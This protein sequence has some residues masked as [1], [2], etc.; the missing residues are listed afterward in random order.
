MTAYDYS[1]AQLVEEAG[2]DVILVGDSV[3]TTAMG[4]DSTLPV[5]LD[6]MIYH[7]TLVRRGAPHTMMVVDLPF[8]T[9]TDRDTALKSAGRIMQETRADAVKLE[10]GRKVIEQVKALV[11]N[12][13]PVVGHLGL[14]PQSVHSMGGYRVQARTGDSITDLVDDAQ[15]LDEAGISALVLEGIPDRVAAYVTEQVS[16]PTI[17]IGAGNQTDGQV[18]V[19]HDGLGLSSH[20]P[21]FAKPFADLRGAILDGLRQYQTEV[22]HRAFP[23]DAHSYHVPEKEWDEFLTKRSDD[24]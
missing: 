23:D 12:D 10:G 11:L 14:T 1:H 5:T 21:K 4:Y 3:G 19:F 24:H 6:N 22:Q 18:L 9:Y 20:Y 17:G 7:A 13:I 8:L 2:I 15:A 16:I